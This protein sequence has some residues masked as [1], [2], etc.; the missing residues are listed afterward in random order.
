M[1][2][3][4]CRSGSQ[5]EG[6]VPAPLTSTGSRPGQHTGRLRCPW[7]L[8]IVGRVLLA[9]GAP[10]IKRVSLPPSGLL[11]IVHPQPPLT[12]LH[13]QLCQQQQWPVTFMVLGVGALRAGVAQRLRAWKEL[14]EALHPRAWEPL[15][16]V[17]FMRRNPDCLCSMHTADGLIPSSHSTGTEG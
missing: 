12:G 15:P 2:R 7:L 3:G 5:A 9:S 4:G 14:G 8:T 17:W 10:S 1:G 13:P 16:H 11:P 6:W